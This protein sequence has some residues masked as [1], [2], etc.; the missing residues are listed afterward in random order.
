L[1]L[2]LAFTPLHWIAHYPVNA[3]VERVRPKEGYRADHFRIRGGSGET[4][5]ILAFSGGGTRAAAFSYGVLEALR[6]VQVEVG[7]KPHPLLD[8]VDLIT[9]VSGGSFTAAYYG[10]FGKRIFDDFEEKFLTADVQG[11][12]VRRVFSP[13]NLARLASTRFA[14]SDL[15]AEY[16][17][18]L[19]FEG[20]TFRD[21][22]ERTGGPTILINASDIGL[23]DRFPFDQDTFD[24]LCSDL[25]AFPV[26][27]AVAASAAVPVVLSAITIRNYA[28]TCGYGEPEWIVGAMYE[29]DTSSRRY[30]RAAMTRSYQSRERRPFIHLMDG[31][32]SDNLGVRPL[33]DKVFFLGG[34]WNA[35]QAS[36]GENLRRLVIVVV[37]A[38]RS[39]DIKVNTRE[40]SPGTFQAFKTAS[41][42]PLDQYTFETLDLL[43]GELD[44]WLEDIVLARCRDARRDLE[45]G[46]DAGVQERVDICDDVSH[47]LVE[48][49]L[50]KL[51]DSDEREH[52]RSLPTTFSLERS[53]VARLRAAGQKLLQESSA[54]RSLLLDLHAF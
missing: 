47:Y 38:Q 46:V 29:R 40:F 23:S 37:N 16:Y 43:R 41:R 39:P 11:E 7:G 25:S 24:L 54:F 30:H 53:D 35:V 4:L 6:D 31:G 9:A 19:L 3:P 42:V 48:V 49:D 28:G 44:Q 14:R 15:A 1:G 10:L 26:A 13:W 18:E 51:Q 20:A 2:L 5:L 52:L 8:E 50:N 21:L 36:G 45:R 27:R 12:L 17:D 33:M 34:A 22:N 32:L